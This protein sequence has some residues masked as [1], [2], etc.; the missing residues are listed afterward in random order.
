MDS[1][2]K[3]S[4]VTNL[5]R[6]LQLIVHTLWERHLSSYQATCES[7]KHLPHAHASDVEYC[8]TRMS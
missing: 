8:H 2:L 6:K 3:K 5:K 1:V 7:N 4:Y